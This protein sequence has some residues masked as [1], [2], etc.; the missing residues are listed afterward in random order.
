MKKLSFKSHIAPSI[1]S[2]IILG[3]SLGLLFNRQLAIDS[4]RYYQYQPT[5]E[6]SSITGQTGMSDRGKFLFYASRPELQDN[7]GF[8]EACSRVEVSTMVLGCYDGDRIYIY[9]VEDPRVSS[10]RST[11][12]AHEMLHA[13]YHR[14]SSKDLIQVNHMLDIEYEALKSKGVLTDRMAY[15]ER[16]APGELRNEL[17]SIIGTEVSDISPELEKYYSRYFS[18][19]DKVV[20]LHQQYS[21]IFL[22]L[23]NQADQLRGE[24]GRLEADIKQQSNYYETQVASLQ[25]DVSDF[26]SRARR[27]EF[28]SQSAFVLERQDLL[29]RTDSL[30]STRQDINDKVDRYNKLVADLNDISIEV[31]KLNQSLDSY[32]TPPPSIQGG[33]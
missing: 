28:S 25:R 23:K 18:D 2:V 30:E 19:R 17:H 27:G 10:I 21:T 5:A 9:D 4:I 3:L 1:L 11:T 29:A 33:R 22:E 16:T 20:A 15:Y 32:L 14:L 7:Q 31:D 24:A 8:N 13:A 12:A 26:N 6:I